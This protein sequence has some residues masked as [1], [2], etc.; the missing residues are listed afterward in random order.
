MILNRLVEMMW[1][2][3][4][5][6]LIVGIVAWVV[7]PGPR[8]GRSRAWASETIARW[9]RPVA[10][11]PNS[12]TDFVANWKPTIEVVAVAAGLIYIFFG[13]PPTGFSVLLTAVIVLIVVVA[14]EV[15]AAPQPGV[16]AP[17]GG[18]IDAVDDVGSR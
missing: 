10:A 6:A 3:M 14:T 15:L 1:A 17:K 9:R 8:A 11:D 18:D 5:L 13:P 12:F 16:A 7:G 2:G 4:I